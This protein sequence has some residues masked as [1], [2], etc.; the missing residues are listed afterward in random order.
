MESRANFSS[1]VYDASSPVLSCYF[2]FVVIHGVVLAILAQNSFHNET[3]AWFFWTSDCD[4]TSRQKFA[5][6]FSK[7]RVPAFNFW[8]ELAED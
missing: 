5:D 6:I 2:V 4:Q 7:P 3:N 1:P 8:H